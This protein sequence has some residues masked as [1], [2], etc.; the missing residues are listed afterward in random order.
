MRLTAVVAIAASAVAL[1]VSACGSEAGGQSEDTGPIKVGAWFPL[2]GPVA[3]TGIP[4]RA[5]ARAYFRQL[6][7]NGGINGRK[8][9]YITRDNAYDPAQTIQVAR[10]LI[11]SDKVVAIVASNGTATTAAAFPYVLNQAKV[12]ILLT[13][14]G[15]ADWYD[16]PKPMLYGFQTLYEH[17]TAEAAT[18]AAEDGAKNILVIRSDPAAFKIAAAPAG[19]AAKSVDPSVSVSELVVKFQTTDYSPV[20]AQV[21]RKNPDAVVT[22]L[23]FPELSAYLKQAKL[24]GLDVPAYSYTGAADEGLLKLAGSAAE[25]LKLLSLTKLPDDDSPA[26]REYRAAMAKYEPGQKP[27]LS[28]AATYAAAKAFTEVVKGIKGDVT[29]TTIADAFAKA[30]SVETGILPP[31]EFSSSTHLGTDEVQRVVVRGGKFEA[32]GDFRKPPAVA[33]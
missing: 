15:A 6:N 12:P 19:P 29:P 21:K 28:S 14:G 4:Q 11:G 24:Q 13:Y 25:G 31:L 26:M 20:V 5:G 2:T 23:S 17:A 32:V 7:A 9:D 27:T 8:V 22:V 16:P 3:A 33:Q 30:G 10:S 1:S 18:W